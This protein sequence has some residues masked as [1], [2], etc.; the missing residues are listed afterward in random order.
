MASFSTKC[1]SG[2]SLLVVLL[3]VSACC[4]GEI[5]LG[6]LYLLIFLG[7]RWA[8]ALGLEQN[9]NDCPVSTDFKSAFY[10]YTKLSP[11]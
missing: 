8:S 9:G 3:A 2:S 10:S 7:T 6:A 1:S 4:T 11:Q 5:L